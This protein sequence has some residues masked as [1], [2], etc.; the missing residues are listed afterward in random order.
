MENFLS[1]ILKQQLSLEHLMELASILIV[2]L[3]SSE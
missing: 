1:K 3:F 2:G